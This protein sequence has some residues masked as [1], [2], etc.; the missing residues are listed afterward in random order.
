MN[1]NEDFPQNHPMPTTEQEQPVGIWGIMV[2]VFASPV[3]AFANYA[4]RPRIII[5]VIAIFVLTGIF[6]AATSPQ[7]AQS[8]V[9]MMKK[10]TSLP[11]QIVEQM[12]RDAQNKNPLVD[13]VVGAVAVTIITI[14][15]SLLAWFL[16]SFFFGGDSKFKAVWGVSLL[17]GLIPQI[18]NL[19]KLPLIYAKDT[20]YVSY[21]LAAFMPGKDFT[22]LLFAI[23]FFFDAFVIWSI[24]VEGIG[25]SAV[26]G[27]SRGKGTAVAI[28]TTV[29]M[30]AIYLGLTVVGMSFAGVEISFF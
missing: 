24:I 22:S 19:L 9:D 12:Q 18:G 2:N 8:Q 14:I 10:S 16:G 23:L 21:G 4:S 20:L 13:G 30:T 25:F 26:F 27:F 6:S 7:S 5:P 1:A 17:A 29:V 11:P 15:S 3:K 28:I